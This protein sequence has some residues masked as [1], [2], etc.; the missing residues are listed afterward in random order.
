ME[1]VSPGQ[2]NRER[3]LRTKRREY[4]RAKIGEYWIVDPEEKC[5]IVLTLVGKT[6]KVHG[7]FGPGETAVSKL[8]PGFA[9]RVEDVFAAGEGK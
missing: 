9:V 2:E 5:I 8:L 1:V 6:Y 4:A 3:D 7:K